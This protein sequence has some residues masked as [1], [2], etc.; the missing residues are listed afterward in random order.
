[1]SNSN[2]RPERILI[3]ILMAL[4]IPFTISAGDLYIQV[5]GIDTGLGGMILAGAYASEEGY[6]EPGYQVANIALAA[7]GDTLNGVFP[8]L[9]SG[10]YVI[11]ILHDTD[12]D[13]EMDTGFLGIPK[14]GYGFSG[15]KE[16]KLKPPKF[17]DAAIFLDDNDEKSTVIIMKYM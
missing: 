5:A 11:A 2:A 13:K 15:A 14:E 3:I 10:R 17:E 12:G 9:P 8:D 1:M 7:N 6:L 4:F 16:G